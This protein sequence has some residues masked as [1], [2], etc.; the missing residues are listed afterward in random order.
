MPLQPGGPASSA[1]NYMLVCV[2][3]GSNETFKLV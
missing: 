3:E 2:C 1:G